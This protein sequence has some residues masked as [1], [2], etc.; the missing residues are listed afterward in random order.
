MSLANDAEYK[1][2]TPHSNS[3]NANRMSRK[4]RFDEYKYDVAA[5]ELFFSNCIKTYSS[6]CDSI[7]TEMNCEYS[8]NEIENIKLKGSF[9]RH[10]FNRHPGA[11]TF[12]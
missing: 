1:Q 10:I 7:A 8:T 9:K 4:H 3:M 12:Q 5:T 2:R 11:V 6:F